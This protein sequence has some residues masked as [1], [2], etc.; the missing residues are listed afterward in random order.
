[1]MQVNANF[2]ANHIP[3]HLASPGGSM[4]QKIDHTHTEK[5][6]SVAGLKVAYFS[7]QSSV[8]HLGASQKLVKWIRF[9]LQYVEMLLIDTESWKVSQCHAHA[10]LMIFHSDPDESHLL[11]KQTSNQSIN[12]NCILPEGQLFV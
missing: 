2:N 4:T 11:K 12:R 7:A 10:E 6:C 1:M 9:S 3:V 5:N 8:R